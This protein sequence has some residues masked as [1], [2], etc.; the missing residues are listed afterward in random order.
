MAAASPTPEAREL[1]LVG[2]VE[3]RIALADGDEKLQTILGTFLPPLLLKLASEHMSVRNK[4][5]SICQHISTRIKPDSIK[6]PV[7]AL[8]E[9]FKANPHTPLIRHFDLLYIQQGIRRLSASESAALFPIIIQGLAATTQSSKEYGSQTFNFLLQLISF[10]QLPPR[11]SKEDDELRTTLKLTDE[12]TQFLASWFGKLMIFTPVKGSND[13]TSAPGVTCPGLSTED[14]AFL[15]QSKPDTWVPKTAMGLN[16]TETKVKVAKLLASGVFDDRERFLP[17]LFASAEP[18]TS[19]AGVGE[20]ILKRAR[21]NVSLED[22]DLVRTLFRLYFGDDTPNGL[23]RVRV[24]LRLKIL[25]LLEKST[26]STGFTEEVIKLANDGIINSVD[27]LSSLSRPD[28]TKYVANLTLW[29]GSPPKIGDYLSLQYLVTAHH[30]GEKLPSCAQQ[31]S[32]TLTLRHAMAT[33][34][35]SVS[36]LLACLVA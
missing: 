34:R 4:V 29:T 31:Y 6:L 3:M 5:I 20:D 7:A 36:L 26:I 24:P 15:S 21:P 30:Q 22:L 2:K 12:D 11:G 9:Q 10:F 25:G 27:D 32:S 19:V 13:I 16:L 14:Y 28:Y 17:A 35:A 8:V 23:M 18:A 33:Q 1:S